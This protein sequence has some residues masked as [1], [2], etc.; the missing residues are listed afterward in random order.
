MGAGFGRYVGIAGT[1][2][3]GERRMTAWL[4]AF[5][6]LGFAHVVLWLAAAFYLGFAVAERPYSERHHDLFVVAAWATVYVWLLGQYAQLAWAI[7]MFPWFA[8]LT[9]AHRV[10]WEVMRPR[11]KGR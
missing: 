11:Q 10:A 6:S 5:L 3:K 1:A 2:G 7:A 4:D 8:A 9:V